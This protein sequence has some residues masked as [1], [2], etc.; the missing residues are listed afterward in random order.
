MGKAVS[1]LPL[2]IC[3]LSIA[4]VAGGLHF[5]QQTRGGWGG[6]FDPVGPLAAVAFPW[7]GSLVASRRPRD[8]TGWLLCSVS[9]VGV[10][11]FAEHYAAYAFSADPPLLPGATW[12]AWLG[13]WAWIP[14]M[15]VLRTLVVLLFPDGRPPSPAWRLVAVAS[16]ALAT[17]A[18]VTAALAGSSI[19]DSSVANPVG[20]AWIPA[21]VPVFCTLV[22]VVVVGPVC[23]VGLLVRYSHARAPV[24]ER[25][26]LFVWAA[27][28]TT[29]VPFLAFLVPSGLLPL[30]VYR[31]LGLVSEALLATAVLHSLLRAEAT[32][33]RVSEV[34]RFIDRS[35]VVG[36]AAAI[37]GGVYWTTV[38]YTGMNRVVLLG[39]L[40]ASAMPLQG[41]LT[42][43]LER[44]QSAFLARST[45][46]AL[47]KRLDTTVAPDQILPE[48]AR[49]VAGVL[50]L[51]Y[52]AVE[53][54]D[55]RRE[56]I[57]VKLHGDMRPHA[58]AFDLVHGSEVVGRL[59]V[60]TDR[61][62]TALG[63]RDRLLL[64]EL[65]SQLAVA[66]YALRQTAALERARQRL[67][68]QRE[69]DRARLRRDH[70]DGAKPALSGVICEIDAILNMC[71]ASGSTRALDQITQQAVSVKG[72]VA[73]IRA[74]L[75]RMVDHQGPRSVDELGLAGAVR[76]H[77]SPLSMGPRPI[78]VVVRTPEEL[79][80]LPTEIE[81]GAFFIVSEAVENVRKHAG[82]ERCTVTIAI[83]D[84][85]LQVEVSDD[86]HGL[87]VEPPEGIGMS[88]MEARAEELEGELFV[89]PSPEGG[90][91]IRARLPLP[92]PD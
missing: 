68:T 83:H 45:L 22:A 4:A 62:D 15:I 31:G 81:V 79:S 49:T 77:V 5:S 21:A 57:A 27:G 41:V 74:D 10:A 76:L 64:E 6:A 44:I 75:R 26:K 54:L 35:M 84:G 67:V 61:P 33:L 1:A 9:L 25:L 8:P 53:V 17:V 50:D 82:A 91:L 29:A 42:V 69:E 70:H 20:I 28:A 90:T 52:V 39:L 88:S 43:A 12:M 56:V 13:A 65:S 16:A 73:R 58:E 80:G 87:G 86:G 63:A 24:R 46:L 55:E 37:L 85:H 89:G 48:I 2:S 78:M 59:V 7:I 32:G 92:P 72:K 60:A 3:W 19:P 34:R 40:L 14:G 71:E 51:P 38:A 11:F 23:L 36:A 30:A 66:A 47:A 18:T